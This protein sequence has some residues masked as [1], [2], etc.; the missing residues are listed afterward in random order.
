MCGR[1][2]QKNIKDLADAFDARLR[3]DLPARVLAARFNIAP[4]AEIG[5]IGLDRS[6]SRSVTAMRWGL[7]P[8]WAAD[9]D[10]AARMI[11]AR[12]ET[13]TDK[14]SFREA[15]QKRRAIIPAEGFY[16]WPQ[17]GD[18]KQPWFI[19]QADERPMA[20]AALWDIWRGGET[21]LF[22]CA[23]LT[24]AANDE[25]AAIHERTPVMLMGEAAVARWLDPAAPAPTLHGLMQAPAIGTLSLRLVTPRV[26]N[27]RHDDADLL[28]PY[29]PDITLATASMGSLL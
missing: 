14:P 10:G 4:T 18:R 16:E 8:S 20:F 24:A 5:V 23:I 13:A 25:L 17:A 12:S 2:V 7:V 6:G 21:A 29:I 11:N 22:T 1:F 28:A 9:S 19:E 15:W 3:V 27:V 26:N